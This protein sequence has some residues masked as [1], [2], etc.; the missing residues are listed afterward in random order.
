[1]YRTIDGR[2][3]TDTKLRKLGL[4]ARYL[5]LYLITNP[6]THVSGLYYL[7]DGAAMEETGLAKP[8]LNTLYDTLSKAGICSFDRTLSLI[9][10]RNMLRY[11]GKGEKV[12]RGA[13]RHAESLHNCKL[14]QDFWQYYPE[15]KQY[16]SDTLYGSGRSWHS[17]QEKEQEQEQEQEQDK[18]AAVAACLLVAIPQ[19][20]DTPEFQTAWAAWQDFR[21]TAKR[22]PVSKQAAMLAFKKLLEWGPA[23]A[24]AAIEHSIR[25]DYQGIFEEKQDNGRP[26]GKRGGD[27]QS[28]FGDADAGKW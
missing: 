18:G 2:F 20:L 3:W 19:T 10:V 21:R 9:W 25:N 14:L 16:R 1:M 7:P 22:K 17:E 12:H 24:V 8:K 5:L 15:L 11:Q 27:D 6:H 13:V 28:R 23:R 26:T 4:E